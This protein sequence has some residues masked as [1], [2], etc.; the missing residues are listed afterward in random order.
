MESGLA[1]ECVIKRMEKVIASRAELAS[2]LA[3][4]CPLENDS[5]LESY[6]ILEEAFIGV[7]ANEAKRLIALMQ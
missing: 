3:D 7:L 2:V 4:C 6:R 1:V 5:L